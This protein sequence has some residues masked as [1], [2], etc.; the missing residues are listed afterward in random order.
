MTLGGK[1]IT[2]S[3]HLIKSVKSHKLKRVVLRVRVTETTGKSTKLQL[4]ITKLS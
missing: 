1:A 2:A 4:T 3:E